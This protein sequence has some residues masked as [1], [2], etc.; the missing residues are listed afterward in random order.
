MNTP[1][2]RRLF[3]DFSPYHLVFLSMRNEKKFIFFS[4]LSDKA[5]ANAKESGDITLEPVASN[6][7]KIYVSFFTR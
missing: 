2:S 6:N 4:R 5:H 7:G 1:S 3:Q